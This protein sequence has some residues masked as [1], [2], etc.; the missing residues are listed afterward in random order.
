MVPDWTR[1]QKDSLKGEYA[2][3]AALMSSDGKI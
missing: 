3:Q 1:F 2:R